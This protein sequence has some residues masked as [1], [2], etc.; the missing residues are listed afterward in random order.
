LRIAAVDVVQQPGAGAK[1]SLGAEDEKVATI[2]PRPSERRRRPR[3]WALWGRRNPVRPPTSG[4]A[5]TSA[6]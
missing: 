5:S 6:W 2:G 4:T 1:G 3:P